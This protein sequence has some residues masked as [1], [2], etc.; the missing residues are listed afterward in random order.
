MAS[1]Y[2]GGWLEHRGVT[3]DEAGGDGFHSFFMISE[4][5]IAGTVLVYAVLNALYY[6]HRD[7]YYSQHVETDGVIQTLSV[8]CLCSRHC[9]SSK[10]SFS[11]VIND[12]NQN[13]DTGYEQDRRH[14]CIMTLFVRTESVVDTSGSSES[15]TCLSTKTSSPSS[16][17]SSS[18]SPSS[19]LSKSSYY[20][21]AA[22]A[23]ATDSAN[24]KV[25]G[26]RT[27]LGTSMK[28]T[29]VVHGEAHTQSQTRRNCASRYGAA[30]FSSVIQVA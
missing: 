17:S 16:S 14:H 20:G 29:P 30:V 12:D 1:S 25:Q 9:V 2:D 24:P 13:G 26:F 19:S 4:D 21:D 23:T 3:S 8:P 7:V 18:S 11:P 6:I 28:A 15:Q 27:C 10:S 5:A 22:A